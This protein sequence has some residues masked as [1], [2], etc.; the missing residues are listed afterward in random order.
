MS[1]TEAA[2]EAKP[3]RSGRLL[4]LVRALIAYGRQVATTLGTTH[5]TLSPSDIT[6]I[7]RRIARGLLRAEALEAKITCDAARLDAEPKPSRA[8]AQSQGRARERPARAA[9][10]RP[11]D[12]PD[13]LLAALPTAEQIAAEVRRRPIGA[14][15][16]DI[17]RDIGIIPSN[18][19]WP[20]IRN[21]ISRYRGNLARL[22][23]DILDRMFFQ[24]PALAW[25]DNPL[26]ADALRSPALP[27]TG[28]P[29]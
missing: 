17:C 16:A 9:T 3:S 18:K 20:E 26:P 5:P 2:P 12:M 24:H 10:S 6:L 23:K 28:P 7:L 1:A 25:P 21:F 4:A 22:V 15:I 19:L 27:G 13:S 8:R 14:V 29:G 11:A